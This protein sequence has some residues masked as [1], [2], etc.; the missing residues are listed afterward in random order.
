VALAFANRLEY[1]AL[2]AF[3]LEMLD[4]ANHGQINSDLIEIKKMLSILSQKL[5]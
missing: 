2:M 5:H 3:D 1:Y 4:E